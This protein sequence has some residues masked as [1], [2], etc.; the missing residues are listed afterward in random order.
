MGIHRPESAGIGVEVSGTVVIRVQDGVVPP[1][2]KQKF[3]GRGRGIF[4]FVC[5]SIVGLGQSAGSQRG[6]IHTSAHLLNLLKRGL[7]LLISQ[8]LHNCGEI[9]CRGSL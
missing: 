4:E 8:Q 6:Q 1:A 2:G 9:R 7:Q 3:V 5:R